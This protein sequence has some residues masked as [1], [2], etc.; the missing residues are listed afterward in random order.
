MDFG[1]GRHSARLAYTSTGYGAGKSRPE[2]MM[3]MVTQ[4][5]ESYV[6]V[7]LNLLEDDR[8]EIASYTDGVP[9]MLRIPAT[10]PIRKVAK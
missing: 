2:P 1:N 9:I 3:P 10:L 7:F 6:K 5:P 4:V 8:I